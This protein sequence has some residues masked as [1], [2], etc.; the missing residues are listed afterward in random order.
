MNRIIRMMLITLALFEAQVSVAEKCTQGGAVWHCSPGICKNA[1]EYCRPPNPHKLNLSE[2]M[3]E[4]VRSCA[5][6]EK[7]NE[8]SCKLIR[9][10][11][12]PDIKD[13]NTST[14]K[15]SMVPDK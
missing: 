2:S 11:D 8:P 7:I 6:P 5:T 15:K 10:P 3:Q 1:G 9:T 12:E 14:S 4:K 13:T